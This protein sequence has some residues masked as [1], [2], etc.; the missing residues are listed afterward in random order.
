MKKYTKQEM[1]DRGICTDEK[2][3]SCLRCPFQD[4]KTSYISAPDCYEENI[5]K[6]KKEK[7]M[8][9]SKI[10]FKKGDVIRCIENSVGNCLTKDTE[11]VV[12]DVVTEY[13]NDFVLV[14]VDN[15][16]DARLFSSR[17]VLADPKPSR[18]FKVGV[19]YF[20]RNKTCYYRFVGE[21]LDVDE[22]S[23]FR[24]IFTDCM[25]TSIYRFPNGCRIAMTHQ[26]VDV[27]PEE[28]I[29]PTP[30]PNLEKKTFYRPSIYHVQSKSVDDDYIWRLNKSDFGSVPDE[31]EHII[32]EEKT[33]E[34]PVEE[35]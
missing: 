15:G 21:N 10:Q 6:Y 11:Y 17:F 3:T 30:E 31:N 7:E 20:A 28:Y 29:E 8:E 16:R 26:G 22:G 27:L 14:N 19:K 4:E 33:F 12:K 23:D 9:E 35:K 13:G 24:M 18:P 32:W 2:I 1:V 25:G 5:A 34:V